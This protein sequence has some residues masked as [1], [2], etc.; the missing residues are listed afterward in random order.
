MNSQF[1]KAI[2]IVSDID[3]KARNEWEQFPLFKDGLGGDARDPS[4]DGGRFYLNFESY[5][6]DKYAFESNSELRISQL[7]MTQN[8]LCFDPREVA[9]AQD[10]LDKIK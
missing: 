6:N 4:A 1:E 2:N 3:I 10:Y 7:L 9:E 8:P 5:F